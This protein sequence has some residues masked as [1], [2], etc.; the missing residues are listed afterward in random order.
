MKIIMWWHAWAI[1]INAT[2]VTDNFDHVLIAVDIMI[3]PIIFV[4]SYGSSLPLSKLVCG[5]SHKGLLCRSEALEWAR[6]LLHF[7]AP[8]L[9]RSMEYSPH[10]SINYV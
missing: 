10:Q 5:T 8:T 1:G 7:R 3:L 9:S 2:I 6:N 4:K